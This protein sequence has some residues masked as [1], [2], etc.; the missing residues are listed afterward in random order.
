[1]A[2]VTGEQGDGWNEGRWRGWGG[3]GEGGEVQTGRL[4]AVLGEQ[5]ALATGEEAKG[6]EGGGG[7][8]RVVRC[9]GGGWRQRWASR[10]LWSQVWRGAVEMRRGG[11]G[12]QWRV[13]RGVEGG[14]QVSN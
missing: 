5:A 8:G 11:G 4:E 12:C 2:L 3:G 9:R 10:Q 14:D 13:R 7:G 6:K 1:M